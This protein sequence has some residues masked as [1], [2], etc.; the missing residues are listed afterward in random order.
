VETDDRY[1]RWTVDA[2]TLAQIG[3]AIFPQPTR[4]TVRL[5]A[6]LADQAL[7]AWNK[8]EDSR[9]VPP[10]TAEQK[11]VRHMAGTL[12]LIGLSIQERGVADGDEVLVELESWY[13]G[14]A[15]EAADEAGLLDGLSPP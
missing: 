6:A 9:P 2:D 4:V 7:A 3:R 1:P 11:A 14:G 8:D 10:E 15:C 5:P 13:I 12:A